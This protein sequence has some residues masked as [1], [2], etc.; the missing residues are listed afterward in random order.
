[1]NPALAGKDKPVRSG[2]QPGA[3]LQRGLPGG[4]ESE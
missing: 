1:M 2:L 3:R 4:L